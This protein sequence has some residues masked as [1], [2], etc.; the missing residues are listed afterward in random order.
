MKKIIK[1]VISTTMATIMAISVM[2]ASAITGYANE[3]SSGITIDND[4]NEFIMFSDPDSR[5]GS[6][7]DFTF[8]IR[9]SVESNSFKFT[10]TKSTLTVSAHIENIYT[11]EISYENHLCKIYIDNGTSRE[12]YEFYADGDVYTFSLANLKVDKNS[13]I[14]ISNI[15]YL[16]S[17]YRVVGSGNLTNISIM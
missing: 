14:S 10:S 3:N 12:S 2:S 9:W 11:G 8:E 4:A 17:T 15:D 1:K 13:K 6:N 7:G 5:I 16:E